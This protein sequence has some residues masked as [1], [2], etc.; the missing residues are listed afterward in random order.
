[1]DRAHQQNAI[2]KYPRHEH[3]LAEL[4]ALMHPYHQ[5]NHRMGQRISHSLW[6]L[7]RPD[8]FCSPVHVSEQIRHYRYPEYSQ[9]PMHSQST[10]PL[11]AVILR[12]ASQ[13]SRL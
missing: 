3:L 9:L 7:K 10:A 6:D 4:C 2:P 13:E 1:M 5:A 8:H 12:P 11:N